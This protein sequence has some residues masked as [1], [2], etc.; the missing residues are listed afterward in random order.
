MGVFR[1]TNFLSGY[2]SGKGTIGKKAWEAG[3][4]A[5]FSNQQLKVAVQ[6]LQQA[7]VGINN[8][9]GQFFSGGGPMRGHAGVHSPSNP[10]GKYQGSGGDFGLQSY[11]AA[12]DD[13]H[14]WKSIERHLP[15][16]GMVL[17]AGSQA[18]F[19]QEKAASEQQQLDDYQSQIDAAIASIQQSQPYNPPMS[20]YSQG[21]STNPASAGLSIGQHAANQDGGVNALKRKKRPKD[22]M[23]IA[24]ALGAHILGGLPGV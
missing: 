8:A 9:P 10:L 13:G 24:G 23:S 22:A 16:S 15:S 21:S 4:R 18:R 5:G 11:Q 2:L 20:T 17:P 1:G 7:G 3:K 14:D 19:D 6:Q 12:V